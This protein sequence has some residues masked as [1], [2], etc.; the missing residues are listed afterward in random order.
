MTNLCVLDATFGDI[1]G[2]IVKLSFVQHLPARY[3]PGQDKQHATTIK[4]L[5]DGYDVNKRELTAVNKSENPDFHSLI[6]VIHPLFLK[7]GILEGLEGV[8]LRFLLPCCYGSD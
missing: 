6:A 8:M 5:R 4:Y 2:E 7:S 3:V 1:L